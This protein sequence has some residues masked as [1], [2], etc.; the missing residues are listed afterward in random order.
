M[1]YEKKCNLPKIIKIKP[2]LAFEVENLEEALKGRKIII[3]PNSPSEGNIVAFI[4]ENSLAGE[5]WDK[6][7]YN[8]RSDIREFVLRVTLDV[9]LRM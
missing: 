3:E 9:C 1:R 7:E 4:K 2:H 8:K 5:E 6:R